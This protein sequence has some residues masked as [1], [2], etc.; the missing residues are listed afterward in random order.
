[1]AAHLTDVLQAMSDIN[2]DD[3]AIALGIGQNLLT[4]DG[5]DWKTVLADKDYIVLNL[6]AALGQLL[7]GQASTLDATNSDGGSIEGNS[8]LWDDLRADYNA[9]MLTATGGTRCP[10]GTPKSSRCSPV[11]TRTSPNS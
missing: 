2:P 6:W 9:L 11:G 7:V 10:S 8:A 4:K 5:P 3:A 1:M